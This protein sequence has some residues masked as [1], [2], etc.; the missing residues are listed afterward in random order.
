MAG[1]IAPATLRHHDAMLGCLRRAGFSIELT[2]HAYSPLDS[3]M[4]L[5]GLAAA[6]ARHQAKRTNSK[7][8]N[9]DETLMP[10][11]HAEK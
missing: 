7:A 11:R 2:A 6:A 8:R 10:E 9:Y 5:D 4:I 1:V 3:Y